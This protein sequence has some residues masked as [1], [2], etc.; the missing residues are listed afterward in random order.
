M[1]EEEDVVAEDHEGWDG[2]YLGDACELLVGFGV[3][4]G[5]CDIGVGFAGLFIGRGE[6]F[7]RATPVGPPVN[8]NDVGLGEGV[9]EGVLGEVDRGHGSKFICFRKCQGVGVYLWS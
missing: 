8:K 9:L 7:A 4:L 5:E 2:G 3:D 6:S 1:G